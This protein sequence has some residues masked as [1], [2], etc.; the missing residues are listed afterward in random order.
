MLP[1]AM[2]RA[3]APW[4]VT[5]WLLAI[6]GCET[7]RV[8]EKPDGGTPGAPSHDT[9]TLLEDA[10]V[11][12]PDAAV[13]PPDATPQGTGD[14][15]SSGCD[16]TQMLCR[17]FC[18]DVQ[19]NP[20]HCGSCSNSCALTGQQ[21]A[22]G[23]CFC[24]AGRVF[25]GSTCSDRQTDTANCGACGH[26]CADAGLTG[27]ICS[28]GTCGCPQ[29]DD[30]CGGACVN[31]QYD[32]QNCGSCGHAC[33]A[34]GQTCVS[35]AC[36]CPAGQPDVCA[37]ACVDT[38]SDPASCG[39]CGQVC[40]G[41]TPQCLDGACAPAPDVLASGQSSPWDLV[42][43]ATSLYWT[44]NAG[45][46]SVMKVGLSGGS[47][48]ALS[49]NRTSPTKMVSD[50][51]RL[52]WL[53]HDSSFESQISS[54]PVGGGTTSVVTTVSSDTPMF[55]LA[56]RG[57]TLFFS[58]GWSGGDG[59]QN[60][61]VFSVP[62][63]GAGGAG[64]VATQLTCC[65]ANPQPALAVDATHV[66]FFNENYLEQAPSGAKLSTPTNLIDVS[67]FWSQVAMVTD[68]T[69]FYWVNADGSIGTYTLSG[70]TWSSL[71]SPVPLANSY[72]SSL[73]VSSGYVYWTDGQSPGAV[74]KVAVTGGPMKTLANHQDTPAGIA[75]DSQYVYWVDSNANGAV[76]RAPR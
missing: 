55:G 74:R 41:S 44:N 21:C 28:A 4:I 16:P 7:G 45:A 3:C 76:M 37:G 39:A 38:K 32:M 72:R 70:T 13:S 12:P 23:Q 30:V 73:V 69:S 20:Y 51:A 24:P 22:A 42:V 19:T 62:V 66:Y 18:T 71:A 53:D 31:E 50:G 29:G 43:D 57:S 34:T 14:G 9:T 75:V 26:D 6:S 36:A 27:M 67:G 2:S 46:G 17:G 25:C 59:T 11:P 1:L 63:S 56:I 5:A 54:V 35:G 8:T 68:G 49:S 40:S 58:A 60:N 33:T 47:P 64:S 52:Y 15:S 48:V 10:A 65:F 61:F